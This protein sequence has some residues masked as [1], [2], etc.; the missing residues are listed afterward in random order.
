MICSR[1]LVQKGAFEMCYVQWFLAESSSETRRHYWL[2]GN[3]CL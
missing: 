3:K 2:L 1:F